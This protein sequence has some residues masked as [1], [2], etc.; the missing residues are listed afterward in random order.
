MPVRA[1]PTARSLTPA[2]AEAF[3]VIAHHARSFS[4]ASRLL[5]WPVRRDAVVLYAWCRRADDAVDEASSPEAAR[6]ELERLEAELASVG[7]GEPQS[8]PLLEA[9]AELVV[10][11][12]MPLDYPRELL[13][14]MRMDLEGTHYADFATL[15]L[16]CWRVAGVVGLMMCH[17]MG[18]ATPVALQQA[19][20]LGMAMQLTNICRDVAEDWQRGRLYLPN[21][22]LI[23]YGLGGLDRQLE[24]PIPSSSALPE[25]VRALL[26]RADRLYTSG[27]QGLDA[28]PWRCAVAI[29]AA[30]AI[31]ADIGKALAAQ[32]YDPNRGRAHTTSGRKLWLAVRTTLGQLWRLPQRWRWPGVYLPPARPLLLTELGSP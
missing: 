31:Y 12:A 30:A 9:F 17:V 25:A 16:Y 29:A 7:R 20:H 18:V 28:L 21:E 26:A 3:A 11:R 5:P 10:R 19:A 1:N 4:F 14:G 23:Q 22:L 13:A 2:Q 27:K 6:A 15:D 8:E 24:G 32:G